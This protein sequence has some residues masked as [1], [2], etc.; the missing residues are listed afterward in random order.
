LQQQFEYGLVAVVV[1]LV[2][3]VR[4]SHTGCSYFGQC[5]LGLPVLWSVSVRLLSAL[6]ML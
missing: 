2:V 5:L 4:L 3:V 1:L 6:L